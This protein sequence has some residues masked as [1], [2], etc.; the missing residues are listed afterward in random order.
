LADDILATAFY[1]DDRYTSLL[2]GKNY[3]VS[4]GVKIY[5]RKRLNLCNLKELY[6]EFK[7]QHPTVNIGMLG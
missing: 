3:C 6:S 1:E 4:V 2:P 7:K 5:A